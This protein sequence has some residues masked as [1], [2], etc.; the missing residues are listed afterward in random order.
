M[1][2]SR[3]TGNDPGHRGACS[4]NRNESNRQ[5]ARQAGGKVWP[6]RDRE[7][8]RE[9][10]LGE[11][12]RR[13]IDARR[14]RAGLP[15]FEPDRDAQDLTGLSRSEILRLRFKARKQPLAQL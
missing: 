5:T 4:R 11:T 8:R 2:L 6:S 15:P 13:R 9:R 12:L 7:R 10:V 14:A 3:P 1:E